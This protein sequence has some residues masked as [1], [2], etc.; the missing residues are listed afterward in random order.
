MLIEWE[1]IRE[2]RE[3]QKSGKKKKE[4]NKRESI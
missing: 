1:K 4:A 2:R 3:E